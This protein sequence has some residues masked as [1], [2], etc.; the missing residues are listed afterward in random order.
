MGFG[1]S[2]LLG[3]AA[4]ASLAAALGAA[5]AGRRGTRGRVAQ[6]SAVARV[7]DTPVGVPALR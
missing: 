1:L 4:V 7:A 3:W 6:R 5:V 2:D